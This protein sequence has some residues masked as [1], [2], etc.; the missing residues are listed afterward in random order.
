MLHIP[1]PA[2]IP[3]I[4][5]LLYPPYQNETR[6]AKQSLMEH[7]R[8]HDCQRPPIPLQP[9][10]LIARSTGVQQCYLFPNQTLLI[11]A[12][13]FSIVEARNV[14]NINMNDHSNTYHVLQIIPDMGTGGAEKTTL[15]IGNEL[16]RLGW[17][18]T[19]ASN[20]G[21]LVAALEAGAAHI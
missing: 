20:G 2:R 4:C 3:P 9:V 10:W 6:P 13:I 16:V 18:S 8:W 14:Q 15:D 7:P 19:V 1:I 12:K 21:R 17:T 11:S 5:Q